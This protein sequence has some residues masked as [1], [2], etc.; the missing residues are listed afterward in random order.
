MR[1]DKCKQEL[2]GQDWHWSPQDGY[3]HNS[4]PVGATEGRPAG[5]ASSAG[6]PSGAPNTDKS[7]C[8]GGASDVSKTSHV[9][10]EGE[11]DDLSRLV[12]LP[13]SELAALVE[14]WR[15]ESLEQFESSRHCHERQE[16]A[17][18]Q[19]FIGASNTKSFCALELLETL[20][21]S[22]PQRS[23]GERLEANAA[24]KPCGD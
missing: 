16:Y 24:H 11:T 17:S 2:I 23:G 4:C 3:R 15:N 7:K 9:N 10:A 20:A 19:W 18:E 1:C 6:S 22:A 12:R 14:K 5:F 21:A 13:V 8:G